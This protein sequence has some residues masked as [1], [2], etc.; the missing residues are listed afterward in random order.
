MPE[1]KTVK[2][3]NPW[4]LGFVTW[5]YV[6]INFIIVQ[7][8]K[9]SP[10]NWAYEVRLLA[11]IYDMRVWFNAVTVGIETPGGEADAHNW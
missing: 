1:Q 7:I 3:V 5:C 8:V 9:I 4:K 10:Y 2:I 6:Q 11:I